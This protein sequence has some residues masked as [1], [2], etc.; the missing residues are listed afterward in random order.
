MLTVHVVYS[1]LGVL[2]HL[3]LDEPESSVGIC[4]VILRKVD[5]SHVVRQ[6]GYD[7]DTDVSPVSLSISSN[8]R[9]DLCT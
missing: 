1:G 8:K 5:L 7:I 4:H 2:L 3:K 6:S 9:G